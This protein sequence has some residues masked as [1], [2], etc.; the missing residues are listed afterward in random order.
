M[1][2]GELQFKVKVF[3]GINN[4]LESKVQR[5]GVPA[6]ARMTRERGAAWRGPRFRGDDKGTR[7]SVEGRT[8]SE[9]AGNAKRCI[10]DL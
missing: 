2:V 8:I 7:C 10:F 6:F 3:I 9:G 1:N 4:N 5:E